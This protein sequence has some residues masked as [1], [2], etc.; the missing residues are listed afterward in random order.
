MEKSIL[1]TLTAPSA[2]GKSYLYNYIRDVLKM[3]CLVSTT[4]RAP[5][6]GEVDGVDYIF[7][8]DEESKRLEAEEQFA[9]LAV[10]RGFR[11]GVTKEEFKNKLSQGLAFLIVEP[12][13]IDHYVAPA[14]EAGAIHYKAFIYVDP[15]V[16]IK[17]FK[18]RM[19]QDLIMANENGTFDKTLDSYLDRFHAVLTTETQWFQMCQ[20][21]RVLMGDKHPQEN[22]DAIMHDLM[23]IEKNLK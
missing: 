10:Y 1:V 21:D 20:W 18:E 3:P 19:K 23:K 4:T 7:I 15:D 16:R 5:R 22:V 14:I 17:R 9:E 6:D 2:A 13:G 8:T 11:Y 12:S